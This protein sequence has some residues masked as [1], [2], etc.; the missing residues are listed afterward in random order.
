MNKIS[1]LLI[2]LTILTVTPSCAVYTPYGYGPSV[3]VGY[4][5]PYYSY[6]YYGYRPHY[7]GSYGQFGWRGH[8]GWGGGHGWGM[9]HGWGGGH[10][11]R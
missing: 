9:H 2:A 5:Y 6:P 4:S 11:H 7:Y 1:I 10:F 8:R 3:S